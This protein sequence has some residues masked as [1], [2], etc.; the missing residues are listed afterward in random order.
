MR[1]VNHPSLISSYKAIV[2]QWTQYYQQLQEVS[3]MAGSWGV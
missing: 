2:I 3:D 1:L